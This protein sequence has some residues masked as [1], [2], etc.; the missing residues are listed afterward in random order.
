MPIEVQLPGGQSPARRDLK[1]SVWHCRN[2]VAY[3]V[4]GDNAYKITL[5]PRWTAI[6]N[7]RQ[8]STHAHTHCTHISW[9]SVYVAGWPPRKTIRSSDSTRKAL[10]YGA[11]TNIYYIIYHISVFGPAC[12]FGFCPINL[13]ENS[14]LFSWWVG[15][16]SCVCSGYCFGYFWNQFGFLVSVYETTDIFGVFLAWFLL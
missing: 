1:W 4:S 14:F 15:A 2:T 13:Y 9:W 6:I 5:L 3:D 8:S 11:L 12:P 16:G 7:D 10:K